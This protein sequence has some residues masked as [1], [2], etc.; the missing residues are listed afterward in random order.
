MRPIRLSHLLVSIAAVAL[1]AATNAPSYEITGAIAGPDGGWDYAS[2][3]PAAHTLYVAHGD[4]AMAVDL[5]NG[6]AVRSLG[7]IAKAHAVVPIPGKNLLL[8]SSARDDTVRL[9]DTID[10]HEIAS[11]A[12]GS[13]PDAAFYD[14]ANGHAVVMNAKGGTVSIIDVAAQKV[15]GTIALKAGLE[16]GVMGEGNTLFV[17]NED[18]NE[19]EIADLGTQKV[20]TAIAMPGCEGPTGLGYDAATHQLISACANGKAVVINAQTRRVVRLLDIGKGPDAV[21]M[22][23]ARRLAFIPCGGSGTISVI[24]LDGAMGAAVVGTIASEP[25]ARTGAL[26]PASG[27]LYLPTVHFG[28]PATAGGRPVAIPGTFHV[29]IVTPK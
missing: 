5:A 23:T 7:K 25:G 12:V 21:I 2:V 4:A 14:A 19:I 6:N 22:D 20:G 17:N 24:A 16:F 13:D 11:I 9:L 28:P 15:V 18:L 10:G 8:V 1:V 26:D 3:D 29:A 27:N